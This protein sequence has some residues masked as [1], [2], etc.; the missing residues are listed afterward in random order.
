MIHNIYHL[1]TPRFSKIYLPYLQIMWP[2]LQNVTFIP[3][4]DVQ[5]MDSYL[6]AKTIS[7]LRPTTYSKLAVSF[8]KLAGNK[9]LLPVKK[10]SAN[11]SVQ[12]R[13]ITATDSKNKVTCTTVQQHRS[14]NT[15]Q[16]SLVGQRKSTCNNI[17]QHTSTYLY[18]FLK[19]AGSKQLFPVRKR[20]T[21][22]SVQAHNIT[23]TDNKNKVT[24][25]NVQQ[26]ISTNNIIC[27]IAPT[28]TMYNNK[29]IPFRTAN[30]IRFCRGKPSVYYRR[31]GMLYNFCNPNPRI[32]GRLLVAS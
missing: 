14:Q 4:Q 27:Q 30:S 8:L 22:D 15:K 12:G 24:F 31:L 29:A 5:N 11:D 9:Q 26:H 7:G 13:N 21:N 28:Y 25:I 3:F 16:T 1:S 17:N 32:Q 19:L 10:R 18:L 2:Y 23:S 6:P 20:S